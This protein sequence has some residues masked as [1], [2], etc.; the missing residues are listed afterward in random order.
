MSLSADSNICVTCVLVSAGPVL[1]DGVGS[2]LL[3]I[4]MVALDGVLHV[5]GWV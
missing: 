4:L 3:P 1:P 2:S 5:W